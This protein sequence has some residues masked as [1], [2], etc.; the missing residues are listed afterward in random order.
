MARALRLAEQGLYT[1]HPN[2]RVGCVIVADDR[3]VGEGW[4]ARAGE[5][6][7]EIIALEQAGTH[8]HGATVYVNLEP[9]AHEGRTPPCTDA[10]IHAGVARVVF[11][12]QDPNPR[13]DGE[14]VRR[15][16]A[17]G[18]RVDAGLMQEL[19]EA[20]NPGFCSRMRR[21]RPYVRVKMAMSLDGRTAL[22]SGE[23]QWI[24]GENARLD[25]Q[26]W[27]ARSSAIMSGI[28]TVLSDDPA[29]SL[30]L[31]GLALTGELAPGLSDAVRHPLRI[32][33]DSRLHIPLNAQL[34]NLPGDVLIVTA[35]DDA[36][37][38]EALT[39]DHVE[40]ITLPGDG[41]GHPELD[42][43]M[44][45][46]AEA[47]INEVLVE[48]GS[49]LAGALLQRQLIDELILYVAPTVL[50]HTARG[51]F[52]LPELAGMRFRIPFEFV[53]VRSVGPDLRIQLKPIYT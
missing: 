51:L 13:V 7:A 49:T 1:A 10:L 39:G 47:Q 34:L 11:A 18:I 19:S 27:R 33:L 53:D 29:F 37:K 22:R 40:V 21:G 35:T 46:L 30:R 52:K 42:D 44:N 16:E 25:V 48:S 8:S 5:P 24:T 3:I 15:L 20:L 50:G 23:S 43:L 4:H 9:C 31:E 41:A 26:R 14:G 36:A 38:R 17:A 6:H 32:I 2:P 28:N 45:V 12:L